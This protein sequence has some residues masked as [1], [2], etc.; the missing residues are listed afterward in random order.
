MQLAETK[1][2]NA[3]LATENKELLIKRKA[4]MKEFLTEE[5]EV[6]ETQLNAMGLA[7]RKDV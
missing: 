7:F 3:E 1:K 4:R 5:A 6:F 2:I